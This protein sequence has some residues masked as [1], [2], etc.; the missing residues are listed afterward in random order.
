MLSPHSP[1]ITL[2]GREEKMT[3]SLTSKGFLASEEQGV[4]QFSVKST[5]TESDVVYLLEI[6]Y[7]MR[8]VS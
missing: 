8:A 7:L 5:D 6:D 3:L 2:T 1:N 4:S